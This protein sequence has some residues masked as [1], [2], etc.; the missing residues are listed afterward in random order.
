LGGGY[1]LYRS[2]RGS[3]DADE[4]DPDQE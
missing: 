4:G 2:L 1:F 3:N